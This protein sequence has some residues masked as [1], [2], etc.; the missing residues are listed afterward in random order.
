[1][2]KLYAIFFI[3]C[4]ISLLSFIAD[5]ANKKNSSLVS[6]A[7]KAMWDNFHA[8]NY[9][10]IPS[11]ILK[12]KKAYVESPENST[13]NAHL[14]FV[15]LWAFSERARKKADPSFSEYIYQSNYFFKEAI[16]LNPGD[17]RLRGFQAAT[18]ICE[19]ALKKQWT[20][21]AKGYINGLAAIN[22][23]PQFNKFA[24]SLIGSQRNKNSPVY[25]LGMKYQWQ[26]LD[27]CSCNK[28]NKK[29]VLSHPEK[30]FAEL[31]N[32]LE[33]S[34]DE[35]LKRVCWNTWIAPHNLEGFFLNFGD[36]LVKEGHLEEAVKIYS[37]AKFSP[38][39]KEWPFCSILEE[40]IKNVSLNEKEFNK[41]LE[42]MI[43]SKRNQIFINSEFSCVGCHQMS[44][45]E[46]EIANR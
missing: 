46:Y 41:P 43:N 31:M 44:K 39:Y 37:A 6:D 14:G 17:A 9:D 23:W 21:L 10:S 35:K 25:K 20:T 27:D 30:T 2:K 42:L 19:G 26:L 28:L 33:L 15:Y 38:G 1:M 22:K 11:V 40:R 3:V 29:S 36:M 13:V 24:F 8:G 32:E 18:D 12:L 45:K 34:N 16:K 4:G 5:K 7:N